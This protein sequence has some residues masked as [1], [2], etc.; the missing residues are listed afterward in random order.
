MTDW[1]E[2]PAQERKDGIK[3]NKHKHNQDHTKPREC[4]WCGGTV[5]YRE[6]H[7]L[8]DPWGGWFYTDYYRCDKCGGLIEAMTHCDEQEAK[9]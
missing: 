5:C 7:I 9:S 4:K 8:K 6:T 1:R 3:D 2:L